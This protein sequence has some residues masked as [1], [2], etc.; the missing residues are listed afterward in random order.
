MR[1]LARLQTGRVSALVCLLVAI[2]TSGGLFALLP[3]ATGGAFPTSGLPSTAESSRVDTLLEEFPGADQ[4]AGLLVWT[5][6]NGDQRRELTSAD[7]RAVTARVAALAE[8]SSTPAAVRPQVSKDKTAIIA[9]VPL[10]KL[11]GSDATV[12]QAEQLRQTAAI[13]LPQGVVAQLTGG[14]GFQADTTNSFAGADIRLLITTALVVAVLLIVTYRSPVLWL[15]PLVVVAGA[16]GLARFV[17]SAVGERFDI[18]FDASVL[19]ILSVLVFGAGTNYA[20]LLIARYR[21][22]LLR[23]PDRRTAMRTALTGAGP[24]ILAS[25]STV[26][27]SL[28]T[29]LL[30]T[31]AG[32]RALGLAC[33]IGIAIAL[34]SALLVLPAALVVCGRGLFWPFV[35]RVGTSATRRPARTSV[36]TRIGTAV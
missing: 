12:A 5:R 7:Q 27:L 21:E 24:A 15:V 32:N 3:Q 16:D 19:G 17:V 18:A 28:L 31:L 33:A 23:E 11:E 25:G 6:P 26:I 30:A 29:L 14:V 2:V 10:E 36:W 13:E 4:T 20:L 8:L 35:P 34:C 1:L 22:E 9:V